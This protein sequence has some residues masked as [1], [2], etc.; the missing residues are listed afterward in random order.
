MLRWVAQD[1]VALAHQQ[2][3]LVAP[4][5]TVRAAPVAIVGLEPVAMAVVAAGDPWFRTRLPTT[6]Q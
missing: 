6:G 3:K 4:R 2:V 5:F 1:F